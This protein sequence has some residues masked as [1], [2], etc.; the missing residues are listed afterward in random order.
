MKHVGQLGFHFSQSVGFFRLLLL[1]T[2]RY[3][4]HIRPNSQGGNIAAEHGLEKGS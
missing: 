3:Y 2:Y 1:H 4:K